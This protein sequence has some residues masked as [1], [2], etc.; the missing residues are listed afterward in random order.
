MKYLQY[1]F[2][3]S[4][5]LS[6][7][8]E[9]FSQ[10]C[11]D[12]Y[13]DIELCND[14]DEYSST[15][16]IKKSYNAIRSWRHITPYKVLK[17]LHSLEIR[18][19]TEVIENY[20]Y[21]EFTHGDI[22]TSQDCS[23]LYFTNFMEAGLYEFDI[24]W[25]DDVFLAITDSVYCADTC[26]FIDF[27]IDFLNE[28]PFET[29]YLDQICLNYTCA[30]CDFG[31]CECDIFKHGQDCADSYS[32]LDSELLNPNFSY[33]VINNN[34]VILNDSELKMITESGEVIWNTMIPIFNTSTVNYKWF[35]DKFV[36]YQNNS[37]EFSSINLI[38]GS[39]TSYQIN[40]DIEEI[41]DLDNSEILL[42][43]STDSCHIR[44]KL[45]LN[46]MSITSNLNFQDIINFNCNDIEYYDFNNEV[47]YISSNYIHP[48]YIDTS[49]F[50]VIHF[51]GTI[52]L[53][54][55]LETKTR[56]NYSNIISSENYIVI[57]VEH[58]TEAVSNHT[59][60]ERSNKFVY[61]KS[62]EFVNR[63]NGRLSPYKVKKFFETKDGNLAFL[64]EYNFSRLYLQIEDTLGTILYDHVLGEEN[65]NGFLNVGGNSILIK[66]GTDSHI[67]Y[68]TVDDYIISFDLNKESLYRKLPLCLLYDYAQ[69]NDGDGFPANIDCDDN[70]SNI[71]PNAE[72]IPNNGIDEDCDGSD[73]ILTTFELYNSVIKIFPNPATNVINIDVEGDLNYIVNL[74]H[75]N[76]IKINSQT[77]A[78]QFPIDFLTTGIYLL[79]IKDSESGKSR[80][81]KIV[82]GI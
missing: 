19:S 57:D 66:N 20:Q 18:N 74:Y 55:I 48:D 42:Y 36:Y 35:R 1:L 22:I 21:G 28:L 49:R 11:F 26:L 45:D 8:L 9:S 56:I 61:K 60:N 12:P 3:A 65:F 25:L 75:I 33:H 76:G 4:I 71:N 10:N 15:S 81:E 47:F 37:N 51:D 58:R 69:D 44:S 29:D 41:F 79:E 34:Y 23:K 30:E 82:I 46:T 68:I 2:I 67:N 70:N 7:Y 13:I 80:F 64:N 5:I 40:E 6:T 53:D 43:S 16:G 54:T 27:Q 62:G 24:L 59:T 50:Y 73:L 32:I 52:V 77:N 63:P 31:I 17:T 14:L 39:E 38:D 72:E 78:K